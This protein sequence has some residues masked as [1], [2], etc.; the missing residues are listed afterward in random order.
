MMRNSIRK[1]NNAGLVTTTAVFDLVHTPG[2]NRSAV[3][4]TAII[5]KII[6]Y[7]NTGAGV[8]LQFGTSDLSAIP[9]FVQLLPDLLA[10]NTVD[11]IWTEADLPPVEFSAVALALA[12]GRNGLVYVLGSAAGVIIR[13]EIE[14]FGS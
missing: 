12:N 2:I 9:L 11:N 4:R 14:E 5:R 8:T 1:A 6:A 7:N 10:L 3:Q 13:A